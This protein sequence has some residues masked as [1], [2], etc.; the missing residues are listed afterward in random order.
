M[1]A[2]GARSARDARARRGRAR[3]GG[4][5]RRVERDWYSSLI[6]LLK[7]RARTIDDIV[8]QAHAVLRARRSRTTPKPSRSSGRISDA[9]RET[10]QATRDAL[11]GARPTGTLESMETALRALAEARGVARGK[12]LSAA[13]RRAHRDRGESRESSTCSS[14]SDASARWHGS[15]RPCVVW[16]RDLSLSVDRSA[17]SRTYISRRLRNRRRSSKLTRLRCLAR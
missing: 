13:A 10:L 6:E 7:V 1:P 14:C 3:H 5:A 4:G 15:M 16:P 12:D 11:A 2:D 9:T 8:R 17:R